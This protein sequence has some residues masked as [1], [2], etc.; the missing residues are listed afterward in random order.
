MCCV[1][2]KLLFVILDGGADRKD[3]SLA[4]MTPLQSA[5]MPNLRE[6]A[7]GAIKG[8]I[9]PIAKDIAPES[10]AAVFSILGYE[11]SKYTGRGP[12]ESYGAGLKIRKGCAAF[13]CNFATVDSHM[14]IID[15]RAGRISTEDAKI[16]E[17]EVN[18]IDIGL[19]GVSF[20]FKSTIGHRGVCVFYRKGGDFSPNVSNADTGYIKKGNIS[21]AELSGSKKLPEVMPLDGSEEAKFTAYVVNS[22]VKKA[23]EKL[24]SCSMNIERSK[25]G[26]L[27]ANALLLRDAGIDLPKV[28]RFSDKHGMSCA[29][30]AEMPVEKGI[31]KLLGMHAIN[32]SQIENRRKRYS[33]MADL[34]I[35]NSDRY[36]F[37]YVH[38]KGPD[39]PGHDG[40]ALL[41]KSV[42]E[43]IDDAFF[44]KIKNV[45]SKIVITCDHAT[46]C[47]MK[48]HSGD[49]VP[50]MLTVAD[51]KDDKRIL[52]DED[53]G[54]RGRM[55]VM[56]GNRL[57]EYVLKMWD[58]GK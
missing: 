37:I 30:I 55:G 13:R 50:V 31:A 53:I 51:P 42:L 20:K 58:N 9:Y 4:G 18:G 5:N 8:M 47:I 11:I 22:F 14:N 6:I 10:D 21:V 41:K 32:L 23:V 25:K 3:A 17:K 24:S 46:P 48:A 57:I 2:M 29:F 35:K 43:D 39:E 33:K 56:N 40:D 44:G 38:I 7:A 36:D 27:Q 28:E 26:E 12:L 49:P 54:S 16:L 15:R 19:E 45:D 1:F 52:F 34:A